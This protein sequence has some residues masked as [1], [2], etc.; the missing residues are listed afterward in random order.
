MRE[1]DPLSFF[2]LKAARIPK[3]VKKANKAGYDNVRRPIRE[4]RTPQKSSEGAQKPAAGIHAGGKGQ[5][6]IPSV[7]SMEILGKGG[8]IAQKVHS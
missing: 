6:A 7:P 2:R 1:K 3:S 8:K 4:T 5:Q